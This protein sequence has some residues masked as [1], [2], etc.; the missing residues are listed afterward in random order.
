MLA[1]GHG[2]DKLYLLLLITSSYCFKI[3]TFKDIV[4]PEGRHQPM[5]DTEDCSKYYDCLSSG[6]VHKQCPRGQLFDAFD[7]KCAYLNG[8]FCGGRS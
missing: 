5:P 3:N 2:I 7:L 1:L 4:C 6:A 8:E